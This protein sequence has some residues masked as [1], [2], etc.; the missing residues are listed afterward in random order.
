LK[1]RGLKPGRTG[2]T[3]SQRLQPPKLFCSPCRFVPVHT[4][5]SAGR[6][7]PAEQITQNFLQGETMKKIFGTLAP[8]CILMGSMSAFA[9]DSMKQDAV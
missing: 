7:K 8:A 9:Q 5:I 1:E 3:K 6:R 4:S 2:P